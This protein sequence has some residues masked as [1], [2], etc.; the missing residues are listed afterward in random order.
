M[1]ITNNYE[2]TRAFKYL[3][4]LRDV[5][6]HFPVNVMMAKDSGEEP[7]GA[8]AAVAAVTASLL[9][10]RMVHSAISE[11]KH[12]TWDCV[13]DHVSQS[14]NVWNPQNRR[15][16]LHRWIHGLILRPKEEQQPLLLIGPDCSG[17]TTFHEAMG[18]LLPPRAVVRF[19]EEMQYPNSNDRAV[20][21]THDP[22]VRAK[23]KEAWLMV[24]SDHPALFTALWSKQRQ[25]EGRYLKWCL[26][27]TQ[28]VDW[29]QNVRRL[30]PVQVQ[31][32]EPTILVSTIPR[33]DLLKRLE[34]ERDAF[35]QSLLRY[36]A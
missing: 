33:F 10:P 21:P 29:D 9:V 1:E 14:A 35:R 3:D 7:R 24:T 19:P 5:G 12:P 30:P 22:N 17:K 6:K 34:D 15:P 27:W 16:E 8:G 2:W 36:A 20:K 26:T 13:L 4:F 28:Q 18:L 11:P 32:Y 23:L 31:K 25:R